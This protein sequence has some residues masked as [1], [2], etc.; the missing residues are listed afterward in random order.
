MLLIVYPHTP[1]ASFMLNEAF[2]KAETALGKIAKP[3][4]DLGFIRDLRL[5]GESR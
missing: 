4:F 2:S 5:L 3:S 1:T